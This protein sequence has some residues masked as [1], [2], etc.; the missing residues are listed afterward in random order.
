M[1]GLRVLVVDDEPLAREMVADLV[2]ADPDVGEVLEC[3][4]AA[5]AAR[6]V[7][8]RHPDIVFLDVEMPGRTGIELANLLG[9]AGPVTVFIT[10]FSRYAPEAFDVRATDYVVK[11][12]SDARFRDAL[13]R[14]KT[15]VRERRLLELAERA[16]AEPEDARLERLTLK[17]GDRSIVIKATEIV[18]IEAQ[19][20]YVLVHSDHGRHL[21][22]AT[23]ASLETRLDP[24]RFLRVHRG[25]IVNLDRVTGVV[26][27]DDM[28]LTLAGGAEVPVSRARRRALRA[29][30][31]PRL[32]PR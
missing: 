16:A 13:E 14:A 7:A 17:D 32:R 10:A 23:L 6:T 31:A 22:R 29:A 28:R 1:T 3:G 26:E 12:F 24:T 30:V 5:D 8:S 19:D 15:R 18:W 21:V 4:N 27:G 20:Y 11:P 25:A 9:P 2:R